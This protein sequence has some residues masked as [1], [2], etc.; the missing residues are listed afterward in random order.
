M[1]AVLTLARA[2][3]ARLTFIFFPWAIT[4]ALDWFRNHADYLASL[5]RQFSFWIFAGAILGTLSAIVLYFHLTNP[6]GMRYYLADF[7][8]GYWLVVGT[9]HLSITLAIFLPWLRR[10]QIASKQT[11]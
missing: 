7:K 10:Q 9:L 5:A 6:E 3:E 4:F 1:V 8:N 11:R 2:R